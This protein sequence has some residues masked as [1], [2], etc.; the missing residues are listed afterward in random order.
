M[1]PAR[2]TAIRRRANNSNLPAPPVIQ[3]RPYQ[4]PPP[5]LAVENRSGANFPALQVP[6]GSHNMIS[7]NLIDENRPLM[8]FRDE[9][10]EE[11]ESH[12]GRY[13]QNPDMSIPYIRGS[14]RNPSTRQPV[15]NA[16]MRRVELVG[17]DAAAN[18]LSGHKRSRNNA[19]NN[20]SNTTN[21]VGPGP[22]KRGGGVGGGSRRRKQ[23]RR[24]HRNRRST[25][26]A[27]HR[28]R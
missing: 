19:A 27:S 10:R 7:H 5:G 18:T 16:V 9:G 21:L 22:A 15:R 20:G 24:A 3:R 11:Y 14:M 28:R 8:N 23:T 4:H 1:A 13:Y 6:R 17:D 26:K 25:R 12:F 2:P